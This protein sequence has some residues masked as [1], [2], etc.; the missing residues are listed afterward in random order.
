MSTIANPIQQNE[1]ESRLPIEKLIE[2]CKVE[3]SEDLAPAPLA[4][5]IKN[6]DVFIPLFSKGN[7]SIITGPAKS[8]KTF[9][10][11]MLMASAVNGEF[12]NFFSCP[13]SGMNI[14][15]DTEQSKYKS[16]QVAKRVCSLSRNSNPENFESYSLRVLE[17]HLRLE[18]IEQV[19]LK[20]LNLNYVVIDGIIDLAIDPIT[21][22]DQAQ[23]IMSKLMK[24]T[25]E[26]G[27]H[28]TCVLHYN[29]N[30]ATLL[31]HLGSFSH[32]K[33]DAIIEVLKDKENPGISVVTPV[34]CRESEFKPFAFSIDSEGMPY[35][36]EGFVVKSN[37]RSSSKDAPPK[38]VS[39]SI[40]DFSPE[41][42]QQILAKAFSMESYQRYS[43]LWHNVKIAVKQV[44]N[45]DIGDS[46]A[47][48]FLISY[49]MQGKIGKE[50]IKQGKYYLI[51]SETT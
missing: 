31:G 40:N 36:L 16:Q 13:T 22:A 3:L 33:A 19:L 8:R 44:A 25:E 45:K 1:T 12:S 6:G 39:L 14:L 34:D 11:S 18:V 51:E 10:T 24:W 21:Q 9:L 15:F 30:A 29:K 23:T 43:D 2:S 17:P 28:I 27:I 50:D 37:N 38:K 42:N 46:K 7:F 49:Q 5:E 41:I 26:F 47:K 20:T 35:I 48:D 4:L 32:R